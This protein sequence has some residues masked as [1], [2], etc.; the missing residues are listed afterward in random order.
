MFRSEIS[1][2]LAS[3]EVNEGKLEE[4]WLRDGLWFLFAV[5]GRRAAK[6]RRRHNSGNIVAHRF[7]HSVREGFRCSWNVTS[8]H[9]REKRN[10]Q[11]GTAK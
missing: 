10:M 4:D 9:L 3:K 2:Y 6:A 5:A 11:T 8:H 1:K 7:F